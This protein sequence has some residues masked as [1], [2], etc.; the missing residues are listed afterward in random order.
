MPLDRNNWSLKIRLWINRHGEKVLGPGRVELLEH[1]DR[2]QSISA[3]AK[4]MDMSYRRAWGLVR[5]MNQAAGTPIVEVA[6]GGLHGGGAKLTT[7]GRKLLAEYRR[8]ASR[9]ARA[10]GLA[11]RRN[12]KA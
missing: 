5:S 11:R 9:L 7:D 6:T 3:A 2:L 12:A 8:I 1:I 10:A 4:Q